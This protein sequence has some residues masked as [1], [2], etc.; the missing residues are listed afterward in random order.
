MFNNSSAL[1]H[2]SVDAF[3]VNVKLIVLFIQNHGEMGGP[4]IVTNTISH[5]TTS[6]KV[7]TFKVHN[8][9]SPSLVKQRSDFWM[10]HTDV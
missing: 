3:Q 5:K 10:I 6:L 2:I 9:H 8:M 1:C 4:F 7:T